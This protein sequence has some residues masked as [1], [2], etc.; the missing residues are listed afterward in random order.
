MVKVPTALLAYATLTVRVFLDSLYSFQKTYRSD[1]RVKTGGL[2][3]AAAK[4]FG[5]VN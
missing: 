3:A 4:P 1:E 5:G 2:V